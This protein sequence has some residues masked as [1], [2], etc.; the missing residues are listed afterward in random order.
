MI[1]WFWNWSRELF[2]K[3][4]LRTFSWENVLKTNKTHLI[5]WQL[6][7]IHIY[8]GIICHGWTRPHLCRR[9][10]QFTGFL[11]LSL[12]WGLKGDEIQEEL[13]FVASAD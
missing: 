3:A 8:Y 1:L 5:L 12:S 13:L 10:F 11:S 6:K 7:D 9:V 2:L 4:T